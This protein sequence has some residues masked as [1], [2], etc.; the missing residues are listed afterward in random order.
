MP[1]VLDNLRFSREPDIGERLLLRHAVVHSTSYLCIK[2]LELD[3]PLQVHEGREGWSLGAVSGI[4][5]LIAR[6]SEYF[7]SEEEANAALEGRCW[8]QRMD[9]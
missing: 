3:R 2:T 6:D 4:G 8:T 1:N 7:K 9:L 5:R